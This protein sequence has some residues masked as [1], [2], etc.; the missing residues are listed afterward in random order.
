MKNR[1]LKQLLKIYISLSTCDKIVHP[2]IISALEMVRGGEIRMALGSKSNQNK[3]D[4][5]L[6]ISKLPDLQWLGFHNKGQH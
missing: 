6:Y 2:S 3:L 5:C 4:F 1:R